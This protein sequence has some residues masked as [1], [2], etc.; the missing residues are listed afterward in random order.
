MHLFGRN[1]DHDYYCELL[2]SKRSG[3]PNQFLSV[4]LHTIAI[5]GLSRVRTEPDPLL[6]VP[7]LAHHPIQT[8]GQSS[9]HRDFGGFPSSSHHQVELLAAPL[10]QPAHGDLR[11]FYQQK[12]QHRTALLGNVSQSATIPAGVFQRHQSEIAR[13]LFPALKAI[14]LSDDQHEGQCGERT[15]TGMRHQSPGL[16][17]LLHLKN[18]DYAQNALCRSKRVIA[19]GC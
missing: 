13:H 16:G 18:L 4:L 14:S 3:T 5:S 17:T 8:N 12:A 7:S 2:F 11:C 10:R 15:D 6:I 19:C 9:R 1:S